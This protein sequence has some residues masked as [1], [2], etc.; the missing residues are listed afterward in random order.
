MSGPRFD[1]VS[2]TYC[3]KKCDGPFMVIF[4]HSSLFLLEKKSSQITRF[5]CNLLNT[6]YDDEN[7]RIFQ[8]FVKFNKK[9]LNI[10]VF[11]SSL[12]D[13]LNGFYS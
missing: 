9:T 4:F 8:E 5:E 13:H 10:I 6:F 3:L 1:Q 7:Q 2:L 11:K 12:D